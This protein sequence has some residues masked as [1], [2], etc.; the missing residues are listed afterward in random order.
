MIVAENLK[1][2][3]NRVTAI[4]DVSFEVAEGEILGFLGPNG[5]GENDHHADPHRIFSPHFRTGHG[6]GV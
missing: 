3:Y 1:K 5:A 6:G 4:E 2:T